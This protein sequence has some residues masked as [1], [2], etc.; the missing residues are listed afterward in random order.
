M[1]SEPL[2]PQWLPYVY[3]WIVETSMCYLVVAQHASWRDSPITQELELAMV[4]LEKPTRRLRRYSRIFPFIP[5]YLFPDYYIFSKRFS[6]LSKCREKFRDAHFGMHKEWTS[7]YLGE[8]TNRATP[9]QWTLRAELASQSNECYQSWPSLEN[10]G[11]FITFSPDAPSNPVTRVKP[12]SF[13]WTG[14]RRD[15]PR[16]LNFPI[17]G[18]RVRVILALYPLRL[19]RFFPLPLLLHTQPLNLHLHILQPLT[20]NCHSVHA[21]Y[22]LHPQLQ[23]PQLSFHPSLF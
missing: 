4:A 16:I 8:D 15:S 19:P 18:H 14:S 6:S 7:S 2:L 21:S 10:D 5:R 17:G 12:V 1:V 9:S 23:P 3:R 22:M 20:D 11:R 13:S